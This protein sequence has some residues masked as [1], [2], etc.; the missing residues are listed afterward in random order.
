MSTRGLHVTWRVQCTAGSI[1]SPI[2]IFLANLSHFNLCSIYTFISG[3]T[4]PDEIT[5]FQL[6]LLFGKTKL[7]RIENILFG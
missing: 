3:V 7:T 5:P 2:P 1:T 6:K 4:N